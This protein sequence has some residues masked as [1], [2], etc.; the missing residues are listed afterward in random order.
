MKMKREKSWPWPDPALSHR[1]KMKTSGDKIK[2]A[3][4][5]RSEQDGEERPSDDAKRNM[6]P[7]M[8]TCSRE[9]NPSVQNDNRD[10]ETDSD[11]AWLAL[12][13]RKNKRLENKITRGASEPREPKFPDRN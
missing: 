8:K 3:H 7:R 9:E 13:H 5:L 12:A 10:H 4:G 2:C 11:T 1:P 6:R